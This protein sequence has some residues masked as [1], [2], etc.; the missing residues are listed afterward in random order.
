MHS[1][2]VTGYI[3]LSLTTTLNVLNTNCGRNL[4][5]MIYKQM[6][7]G[8]ICIKRL[9]NLTFYYIYINMT[10]RDGYGLTAKKDSLLV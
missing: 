7:V 6:H 5:L 1:E 2:N 4:K 9:Y 8:A 10:F 3:S